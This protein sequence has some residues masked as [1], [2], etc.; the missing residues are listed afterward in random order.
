M[1]L[2]K[3]E[4]IRYD[5]QIPVIGL[6]NQLKLKNS[7]VLIVGLGGLGSA[8]S[9]YLAA[10][11]VG[12]LVIID[13]DVVEPGNL[14]RQILYTINDLGKS[15]AFVAKDRLLKLNPYI[16]IDAYNEELTYSL[17][18]KLVKQVDVV[19]DALDNW[20]TRILL[21][22]L[23]YKHGKPLVHA[24]VEG[25]YGQLTVVVPGKTP[26][27][28]CIFNIKGETRSRK[29]NVLATT[30]GV[31]GILEANEVIKL[32]TGLGEV[33][34]NKLLIYNGLTNDFTIIEFG[35]SD[36]RICSEED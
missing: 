18:E 15:K 31:L 5:R 4:F 16:E 17:G 1:E 14:Q 6:E 3:E 21:D 11:G 33:L 19:V 25:F 36:C 30:P 2:S 7:S 9:Y 8:V 28:R 32:L 29:V 12:K 20:E 34:A 35:G 10:S 26:C 13:K 23:V 24:G 27:L 22:K